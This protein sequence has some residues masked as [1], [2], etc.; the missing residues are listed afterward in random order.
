MKAEHRKELQT[1]TLADFL[2][3]TVRGVRTGG[4]VSWYK[5]G[6]VLVVAL[7]VLLVWWVINNKRRVNAENW[8]KVHYGTFQALDDLEKEQR[9]TKQGQAARFTLAYAFLWEGI[10]KMGGPELETG[11]MFIDEAIRRLAGLSEEC[12]DDPER[13]GEAKYHIFVGTEAKGVKDIKQLDDAKKILEELTRGDLAKTAYG[14]LAKKRLDQYNNPAEYAAINT[15]YREYR[16]R[17]Q[18]VRVSPGG[19]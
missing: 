7:G 12:K 14:M 4:G 1:N 2:G 19:P 16:A 9:D 5:V 18:D 3:R 6:L 15:F 13:Q 17:S 10:K 11:P 8:A